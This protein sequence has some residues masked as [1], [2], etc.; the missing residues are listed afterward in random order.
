M[1]ALPRTEIGGVSVSRLVAG[2]NWFLGHSHQ[3][4]AKSRWITNTHT[5]DT[6][7]E[8]LEVFL[9]SGVNLVL[10]PPSPPLTQAIDTAQQRVG[11]KMHLITTPNFELTDTG[12]DFDSAARDFDQAANDG[13]TFCWPHQCVTDRLYDGLTGTI[14]HFDR[15]AKMMRER[16]L[17]PGLSTHTP[18]TIIAA[19]KTDLDV[20]S[21]VSIYNAAGFLMP[22][23]ID[24]I[25][26][27][28]RNATKPVLTIKPLAAGRLMPYVGLP[29]VWST[30]RE[31]DMVCIGTTTPDEASEVIDISRAC[32][33]RR[34]P[35][36]ELQVTRSKQGLTR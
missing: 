5:A 1:N 23:E 22:V 26:N 6:I 20:A 19:D 21:Y 2:T 36:V 9:R 17:I 29:F 35:E 34:I 32:L 30:L 31:C 28:I 7:A 8:V 4:A 13:A 10:G 12:P 3:T 14:R 16:D 27:I 15:L 24:W 33:E 18:L 25:G 11:E